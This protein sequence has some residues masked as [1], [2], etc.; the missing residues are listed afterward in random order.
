MFTAIG[1]QKGWTSYYWI[2]TIPPV[3]IVLGFKIYCTRVF[4][5]RFN[6]YQPTPDELSVAQRLASQSESSGNNS[7]LSKR[8][9]HPALHQEL[10]T[11]MVHANMTALLPE[12]Y[13]GKIS[14][15]STK[16]DEYG[17]TKVDASMVA[18]IKIA[19]IE[20]VSFLELRNI[21]A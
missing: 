20:Q 21:N 5:P 13:R 9:G 8:F 2:S 16:L 19:A 1:L 11:P 3:L 10:F 12:V 18:G 7:R 15:T 4:N 6:Y 14:N 17:G